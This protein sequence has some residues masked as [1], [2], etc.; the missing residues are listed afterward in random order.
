MEVS[1]TGIS[2][3]DWWDIL[4]IGHIDHYLQFRYLNYCI[5]ISLVT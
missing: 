3:H 2:G 4:Y 1:K 5:T